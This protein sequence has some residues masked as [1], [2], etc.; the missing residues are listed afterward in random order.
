LQNIT[1]S[2]PDVIQRCLEKGRIK[3]DC[4]NYI[5]LIEPFKDRLFICG[6]NALEPIFNI[7][8][9]SD[10][11][12]VIVGNKNARSR[13]SPKY[14]LKPVSSVSGT[15][16]LI[17]GTFK[18]R[19]G[20]EP[21]IS[22]SSLDEGSNWPQI[23]TQK[24]IM[25]LND[26]DFKASIPVHPSVFI[27]FNEN[28]L[29]KS[30]KH[31]ATVARVCQ[32]DNG[33]SLHILEN[34]WTTFRKARLDCVVPGYEDMKFNTIEQMVFSKETG[35]FH[36][37]FRTSKSSFRGSAMCS[38][39]LAQM[40]KIF[41]GDFL[42]EKTSSQWQRVKNPNHFNECQI[43]SGSL[44][45]YTMKD[46]NETVRPG[47]SPT[48]LMTSTALTDS[49]RYKLMFNTIKAIPK[50]IYFRQMQRFNSIAFDVFK[51]RDN[52]QHT[53]IYIGTGQ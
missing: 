29:E 33:G 5:Q 44:R 35:M 32:N 51:G 20:R 9:L 41:D 10:P 1:W 17:T 45:K 40:L 52:K 21:L 26:P 48:N 47:K 4:Q 23:T 28:A 49:Y 6:T 50:V 39:D 24:D 18:D 27:F 42:Y 36:G 31:V 34:K 38:F 12:I 19:S 22:G 16:D 46:Y 7:T 53:L 43:N 30:G 14:N 13:C 2:K 15:G 25:N 37:V 3:S 11:S 8:K